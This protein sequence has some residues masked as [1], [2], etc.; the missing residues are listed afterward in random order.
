M[1]KPLSYLLAAGALFL[2]AT[3]GA[4]EGECQLTKSAYSDFLTVDVEQARC[5]ARHSGKERTLFYSYAHWWT[6]CTERIPD[7]IRLAEQ[8]DAELYLLLVDEEN[9]NYYS[10]NPTAA[11]LDTVYHNELKAVVITD[12]LYSPR[13]YKSL[14][15]PIRKIIDIRG[16]NARNKYYR[17]LCDVNPGGEEFNRQTP[18]GI[19]IVLDRQGNTV[20]VAMKDYEHPDTPLKGYEPVARLLEH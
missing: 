18:M 3:T 12:S 11:M 4:Q 13:A 19:C 14:Q 10:I 5:L 2:S 20:G 15:A 17:F 9:E 8:Y 1:M 7:I 6:Y 16:K